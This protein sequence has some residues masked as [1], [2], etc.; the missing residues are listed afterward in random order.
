MAS[1]VKLLVIGLDGA[2]LNLLKEYR[3]NF[4]STFP[5]QRQ[6]LPE[7]PK[8]PQV[9][10]S[11]YTGLTAKKHGVDNFDLEA[12]NKV[13][14][15]RLWEIFNAAGWTVGLV[16][17]PMTYPVRRVDGFM[18]SGM[19][20]PIS[21]TKGDLA[22]LSGLSFCWPVELRERLPGYRIDANEVLELE[23]MDPHYSDYFD[24]VVDV[25]QRVC[26]ARRD[27]ILRVLNSKYGEVDLLFVN[28]N[29]IDR[30]G[31]AYVGRWQKSSA[32]MAAA[33][34]LADI[35]ANEVYVTCGFP[36]TIV[37]SD[38]GFNSQA[39]SKTLLGEAPEGHAPDN[40]GN[41]TKEGIFLARDVKPKF[42]GR[43]MAPS[44]FLPYL[45][46]VAGIEEK[47]GKTKDSPYWMTAEEARIIKRRLKGLGYE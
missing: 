44:R 28:F 34:I 7:V 37:V 13:K 27:S 47:P 22:K 45:M 33:Y 9:W 31:H 10:W 32:A 17:L 2:D 41:H 4:L 39:E 23:D 3:P 1:K 38:H 18:I 26:R 36:P 12:A 16:N 35:V 29:I 25:A 6:M 11:F 15:P 42:T 5:V 24:W 40:W 8:T 21:I 46:R 30:V 14:A 20:S 43:K 19:P